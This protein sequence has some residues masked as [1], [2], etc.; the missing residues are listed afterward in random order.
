[1][2]GYHWHSPPCHLFIFLPQ[3]LLQVSNAKAVILAFKENL[4]ILCVDKEP[5]KS[6]QR[7]DVINA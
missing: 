4:V 6:K 5:S 2:N 7:Y 3:L 1:M